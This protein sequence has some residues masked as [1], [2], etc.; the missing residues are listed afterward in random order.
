MPRKDRERPGE[1]PIA[2]PALPGALA[3][4]E[5]EAATRRENTDPYRLRIEPFVRVQSKVLG[6]LT[7]PK[8]TRNTPCVSY[9]L[10]CFGYDVR[11]GN[12]F[13]YPFVPEADP[14]KPIDLFGAD[15]EERTAWGPEFRT[16]WHQPLVLAVGGVLL[17]ETVER[18]RMPEDCIALVLCKSTWARQFISLNTTPLEPGWEGTVTLEIKNMNV[19]PVTLR[20]GH[21]IGQL[22]FVRGELCRAPYQNRP[23]GG[24][25][26]HQ[27]GPTPP[28]V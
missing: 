13:R 6:R 27:S 22:V 11:L 18:I 25:Y 7:G 26:N 21:G 15:P 28:K 17:A 9:G 3:D 12:A 19:R 2:G 8:R 4:H 1:Q 14:M 20:A 23:G 24:T 16:A 5:I 10:T